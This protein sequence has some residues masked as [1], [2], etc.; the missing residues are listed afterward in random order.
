MSLPI[1]K[2]TSS[3]YQGE[4]IHPT[5]ELYTASTQT[6]GEQGKLSPKLALRPKST[7]DVSKAIVWLTT[8]NIEFAV[9]SGGCGDSQ[10]NGVIVDM[11]H[12]TKYN[13][14]TSSVHIGPGQ[15]WHKAYTALADKPVTVLGG[16]V[17]YV[18]VGGFILGG[19]LSYLANLYGIAADS[20][21]D[22]EVVLADG[23]I[24]RAKDDEDLLFALKGAGHA[25]GVVTELIL[26]AHPKPSTVYGGVLLF[27]ITS[28]T[29]LS[30]KMCTI[31]DKKVNAMM[32]VA[33]MPPDMNPA[34]LVVAMKALKWA[35]D[36]GPIMDWTRSM[37]FEESIKTQEMYIHPPPAG[38]LF[39]QHNLARLANRT[40]KR[41]RFYGASTLRTI[42]P[43][44]I[45]SPST[46]TK[47][48]KED[49]RSAWPHSSPTLHIINCIEAMEKVAEKGTV[50]PRYPNY[51]LAGVPAE[52]YY[53]DN[54]ERLRG[55]KKR[56][57]KGG[58]FKT[59]I[60]I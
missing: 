17:G 53:G 15:T 7:L 14:T 34:V 51:N 11:A 48:G 30:E 5:D 38:A 42:L 57:D 43:R 24:V 54:L 39:Q 6:W 47:H 21:I 49:K 37:S 26:K 18:G 13:P 52:E 46:Q 33:R 56:L 1:N 4:I 58:V 36:L 28:F 31:T 9:R 60:K 25:F 50:L 55:I 41:P 27:P 3:G 8:N 10:S 22:A 23:S 12:L 20:L 40:P 44:R 2:L 29:A 16:R 35:W 59:G 32:G 19:G 45:S